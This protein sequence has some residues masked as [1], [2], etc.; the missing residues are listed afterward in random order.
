MLSRLRPLLANLHFVC[1][2]LLAIFAVPAIHHV[3]LPLRMNVGGMALFYWV[4]LGPRS[5]L[6]A[7]LFCLISFPLAETIGVASGRYRKEKVRI[8]LVLIFSVAL[9]SALA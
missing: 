2:I 8:F 1:T 6:C 3:G 5:I 4:G 9:S 7:F